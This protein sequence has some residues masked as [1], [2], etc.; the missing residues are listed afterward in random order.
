MRGTLRRMVLIGA[1]AA[2]AAP[3][4]GEDIAGSKDHPLV[5]RFAG[6]EIV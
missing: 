2:I 5:G 4:L 1:I 6:A 3:A